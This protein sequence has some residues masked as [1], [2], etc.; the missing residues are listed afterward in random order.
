MTAAALVDSHCHFDLF[1]NPR[2]VIQETEKN[3]IH[4]IA[5]TNTP[6]VFDPMQQLTNGLTYVRPAVG[7]HPELAIQRASE[8]PI[9]ERKVAE[10]RYVGE[11]GLD[12][13]AAVRP[14]ERANQRAIF[15]SIL[16]HCANAGKR[17]LTVHSRR[18]E[19]DV[20]AALREY[21]PGP[22]ILHWYSGSLKTLSTAVA[23]GAYFSVNVAMVRSKRSSRLIQ[24]IPPDRMLTESDGPFV[25][26]GG[27]P[28][29]PSSVLKV[30]AEIAHIQGRDPRELRARVLAN[31]KDLWTE[32][33][34]AD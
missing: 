18:A 9:F 16:S 14:A 17:I 26:L 34:E 12:Y 30:L 2:Q 1:Q 20:V 11:V 10:T 27:Q 5:V 33:P 7:L 13:R 4:S 3:R 31:L 6:S 15:E 32:I 8:L 22:F 21:Q 24:E 29:R 19:A 25:Q 23:A 28:A